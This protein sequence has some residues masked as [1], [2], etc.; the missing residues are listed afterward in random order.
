MALGNTSVGHD[1][2][3]AT[4]EARVGHYWLVEYVSTVETSTHLYSRDMGQCGVDPKGAGSQH[5]H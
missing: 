3:K 1:L 4:K 5:G 2:T